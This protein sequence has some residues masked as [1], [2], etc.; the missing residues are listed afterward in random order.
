M[1]DKVEWY[2]LKTEAGGTGNFV[3]LV[4]GEFVGWMERGLSPWRCFQGE[5]RPLSW[6]LENPRSRGFTNSN[7]LQ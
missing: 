5:G 7:L 4:N 3:I 2:E 6:S 1:Q